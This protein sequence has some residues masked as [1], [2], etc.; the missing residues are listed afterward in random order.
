MKVSINHQKEGPQA[1]A[2]SDVKQKKHAFVRLS[3][4]VAREK[5]VPGPRTSA[6]KNMARV[7]RG[8]ARHACGPP[9]G[10]FH[11]GDSDARSPPI[12]HSSAVLSFFANCSIIL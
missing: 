3:E 9:P 5:K 10:S 6:A 1:F 2:T 8:N 4:S 12:S 11:P 7:V